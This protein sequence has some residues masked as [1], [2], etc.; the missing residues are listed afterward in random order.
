MKIH[1]YKSIWILIFV[2]LFSFNTYG[3]ILS[4]IIFHSYLQFF[5][6]SFFQ[7]HLLILTLPHWPQIPK[8][9]YFML[10]YKI[11]EKWCQIL[12]EY[13]IFLH[14]PSSLL[15]SR[16]SISG[17]T[18]SPDLPFLPSLVPLLESLTFSLPSL[19]FSLCLSLS[20]F[21]VEWCLFTC[22]SFL[23]LT[24]GTSFAGS[25]TFVS[26]FSNSFVFCWS[27]TVWYRKNMHH[28][29]NNKEVGKFLIIIMSHL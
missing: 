13:L 17:S 6:F 8:K 18:S 23:S 20:F 29:W 11:H 28:E 3:A 5:K 16:S 15:V 26:T 19:L 4:T 9:C 22:F 14:S 7:A 2:K 12:F 10:F 21:S 27:A 25:L 1:I 24:D